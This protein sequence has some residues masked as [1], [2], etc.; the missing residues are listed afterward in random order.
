MSGTAMNQ[1]V[2]GKRDGGGF[3]QLVEGDRRRSAGGDGVG[4]PAHL[5]EM[6]FV[7]L[8]ALPEDRPVTR[9]RQLLEVVD[10][11]GLTIR[12]NGDVLL[13]EPALRSKRGI[14]QAGEGPILVRDG[15]GEVVGAEVW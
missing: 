9:S 14:D 5:L 2:D 8:A 11:V 1:I 15:G 3:H 4:Q 6:P 10:D 7:R 12:E 13:G